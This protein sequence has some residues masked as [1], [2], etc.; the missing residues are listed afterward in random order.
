MTP[1]DRE[2][3]FPRLAAGEI[4][5]LRPFGSERS[6]PAGEI[7]FAEG[8]RGFAFFVVLAGAVEIVEHSSGAE[9]QVIVHDAGL[10]T[11]DV[12]MLTGRAAIVT[13]RT[14]QPTRVLQLTAEALRESV[15]GMPDVGEKILKAFLQRRALLLHDGFTGLRIVGSRFSPDAHRIRDFATR[16]QI[17]FT[18][19]D[20]ARRLEGWRD[21]G[22]R[23]ARF[24][25]G[26]VDGHDEEQ[27]RDADLLLSF[28]AATWPHLLVRAMLVEQLFRATSILAGH[29][30]H[31]AG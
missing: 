14:T 5:A 9:R 13:A 23:E 21:D 28:G 15:Q 24:L 6:A 1:S 2:L 7:L 3:A 20:L 11:G 12:D 29:P 22:K 8:Q 26:A 17:P 4:E 30:Y 19:L 31:R 10:F 16:N 25:I 27:R 18:W